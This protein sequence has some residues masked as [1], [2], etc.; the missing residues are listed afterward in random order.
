MLVDLRTAK[1]WLRV[2]HDDEDLMIQRL[3]DQ[4]TSLVIDFI[5]RPDHGW[6][7]DTVPPHVEAAIFHVM[8]R[9]YDDRDGELEGGALAPHIKDML[10]RERDPAIA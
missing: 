7:P 8:K 6:T 1:E 4:A 3:A 2:N 5:K 10:W 9:L